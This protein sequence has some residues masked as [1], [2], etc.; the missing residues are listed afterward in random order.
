MV[1]MVGIPVMKKAHCR[2]N[3]VLIL[4]TRRCWGWLLER[5]T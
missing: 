5:Q 4:T 2:R 1:Q 3:M